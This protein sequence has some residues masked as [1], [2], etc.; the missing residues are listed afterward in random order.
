VFDYKLTKRE[1]ETIIRCHAGSPE[2]EIVTADPRIIR[3]LEKKGFKPDDRWNPWGYVSFTLPYDKIRI[4]R[5]EKC[6]RGFARPK[7]SVAL[8]N[9]ED[10]EGQHPAGMVS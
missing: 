10:F 6:R 8:H 1:R 4:M 9:N 5:R 2:W 3:Q 7:D